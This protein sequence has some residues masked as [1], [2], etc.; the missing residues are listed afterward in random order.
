MDIITQ[1][2]QWMRDNGLEDY[3]NENYESEI[4]KSYLNAGDRIILLTPDIKDFNN[5]SEFEKYQD[6][7][8]SNKKTIFIIKSIKDSIVTLDS[9]FITHEN[10]VFNIDSD[11]IP[12]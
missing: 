4:V 7:F 9:G 12:F 6:Y 8:K 11:D 5:Y 3:P 10:N 2:N 1:Y